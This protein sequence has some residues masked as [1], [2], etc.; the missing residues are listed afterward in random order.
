MERLDM[1]PKDLGVD[2]DE[3][4]WLLP[5]LLCQCGCAGA[6]SFQK[7]RMVTWY[8]HEPFREPQI[9]KQGGLLSIRSRLVGFLVPTVLS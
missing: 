5:V 4:T 8:P 7:M 1:C 6:F 9:T 2:N 3:Y